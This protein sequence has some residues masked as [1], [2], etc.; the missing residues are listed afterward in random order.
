M[1]LNFVRSAAACFCGGGARRTLSCA[2]LASLFAAIPHSPLLAQSANDTS[3]EFQ[4]LAAQLSTDRRNGTD[5][6][7]ARQEQALQFLDSLVGSMLSGSSASGLA[8]AN[9]KLAAL[10]SQDPRIGE[11]YR[12]VRLGGS[13]AAYALMVNFGFGGPAAVRIYAPRDGRMELQARI[14][15]FTQKPFFDSDVVLVPVSG[16]EPVFV[17]VSGR[18]DDLSTGVFSA[19][20]FDGRGVTPLWS[21]DILPRSSYK[22]NAQG[23]QVTYCSQPDEDH[24][25][26]CRRMSRDLYRYQDGAW[27][28]ISTTDLGPL[29]LQK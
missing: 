1:N 28:R 2:M 10:A 23:F 25:E 26:V 3:A 18:N 17:L 27:K 8:R 21:S 5:E 16:I 4:N 7:E 15:R 20:R 24:S 29:S 11:S 9:V 19:W 14:D 22:A 13:Q 12:L 6:T